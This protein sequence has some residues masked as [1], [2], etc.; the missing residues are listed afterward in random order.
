MFVRCGHV[1]QCSSDR[2]FIPEISCYFGPQVVSRF[3]HWYKALYP[4]NY[5][6]DGAF[7]AIHLESTRCST[8]E[9][10]VAAFGNAW[11]V[12]AGKCFAVSCYRQG[13]RVSGEVASHD[14]TPLAREISWKPVAGREIALRT[15]E[16]HVS[17]A[18][19]EQRAK[20]P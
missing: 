6:V 17:K 4:T 8:E 12:T 14:V 1:K 9:P 11:V 15:E 13:K 16:G 7:E 5:G 2:C 3:R 19:F 18:V 10:H 20:K